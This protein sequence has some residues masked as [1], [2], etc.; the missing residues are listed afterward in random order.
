LNLSD[1]L[2]KQIVESRRRFESKLL[3]VNA[4]VLSGKSGVGKTSF[5]NAALSV[6][7]EDALCSAGIL[8]I[9]DLFRISAIL[10]IFYF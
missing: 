7:D 1:D 2:K 4:L 5:I 3:R 10:I 6:H 8:I 9:I